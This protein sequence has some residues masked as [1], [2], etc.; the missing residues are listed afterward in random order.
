MERLGLRD[1]DWDFH[2]WLIDSPSAQL[3]SFYYLQQSSSQIKHH[4]SDGDG[5]VPALQ[6]ANGVQEQQVSGD[7]QQEQ[8]AG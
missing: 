7:N 8:D 3:G 5:C 6:E 1:S 4:K 2:C